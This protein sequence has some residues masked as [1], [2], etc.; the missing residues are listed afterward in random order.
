[1]ARRE[2]GVLTTNKC[3]NRYIQDLLLI[4]VFFFFFP[5]VQICMSVLLLPG[6]A[7]QQDFFAKGK[8]CIKNGVKCLKMAILFINFEKKSDSVPHD[9]LPWNPEPS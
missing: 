5:F 2:I 1:M 7:F 8:N 9:I 4:F 6:S 3:S